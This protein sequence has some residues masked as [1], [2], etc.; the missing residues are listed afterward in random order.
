MAKRD[1][2]S[3]DP[4][5]SYRRKRA[6]A[7]RLGET[8][9]EVELPFVV[10]LWTLARTDVERVLGRASSAAL[11]QAIFSAALVEHMGRRV[12]LRHGD[13]FLSDSD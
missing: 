3:R 6:I 7:S 8:G 2:I 13:L 9:A 1:V 5:G 10:E 4:A 12:T 11:A